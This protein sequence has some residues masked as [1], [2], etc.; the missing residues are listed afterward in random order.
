MM[1]DQQWVRLARCLNQLTHDQISRD[2]ALLV[3][4]A[5]F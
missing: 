2:P 4:E 1:N 3:I 5:W